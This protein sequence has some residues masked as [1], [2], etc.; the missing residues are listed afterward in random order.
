M[1]SIDARLTRHDAVRSRT[2]E[3]EYLGEPVI[4]IRLRTPEKDIVTVYSLMRR[5]GDQRK[6]GFGK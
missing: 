5:T 4:R 1:G 2:I 3:T 6:A